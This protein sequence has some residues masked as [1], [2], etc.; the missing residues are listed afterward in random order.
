MHGMATTREVLASDIALTQANYPAG[1]WIAATAAWDLPTTNP[2]HDVNTAVRI[3]ELASGYRGNFMVCPPLVYDILTENEYIADFIRYQNGVSFL[4][5]GRIPDEQLYS[6]QLVKCG[7]VY[8]AAAP[9]KAM[10]LGYI[11]E[12]ATT[13]AGDDWCL[14][15]FVDP[16]PSIKTGSFMSTFAF[17]PRILSDQDFGQATT[18]YDSAKKATFYEF[19]ADYQVLGTNMAAA[20]VIHGIKSPVSS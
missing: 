15:C 12:R 20:V 19:R 4:Q 1:H 2:R 3:I 7:S 14:I 10:N 9:L 8:D 11:W 18:W 5:T 17:N 6:L 16:V 13:D